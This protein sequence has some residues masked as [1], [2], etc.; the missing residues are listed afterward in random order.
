M[1]LKQLSPRFL[2][3]ID[4]AKMTMAETLKPALAAVD[5]TSGTGTRHRREDRNGKEALRHRAR[6]TLPRP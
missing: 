3:T 5:A 1:R 4:E 6:G 2:L